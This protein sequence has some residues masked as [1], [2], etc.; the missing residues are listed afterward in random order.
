MDPTSTNRF[1]VR[2]WVPVQVFGIGSQPY[3]YVMSDQNQDLNAAP[4]WNHSGDDPSDPYT[5]SVPNYKI[6][7]TPT[8]SHTDLSII[9]SISSV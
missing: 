6:V 3:W 8:A 7:A 2:I 1:G 4:N 5:F 9:V